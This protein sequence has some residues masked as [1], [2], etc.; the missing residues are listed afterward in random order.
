[1]GDFLFGLVSLVL[2]VVNLSYALISLRKEKD[3]LAAVFFGFTLFWFIYAVYYFI[4][5]L[6]GV[7]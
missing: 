3:T 1:M 2:F 7:L 5:F 6:I 4:T